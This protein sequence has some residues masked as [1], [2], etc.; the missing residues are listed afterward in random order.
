MEDL[1]KLCEIT[2]QDLR[3]ALDELKG[4]VDVTEEDLMKIYASALVHAKNR[5]KYSISVA[6]LMTKDVVTVKKETTLERP[7]A[8][9]RD[10]AS[11]ACL[12]SMKRRS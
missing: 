8:V 2:E 1:T 6:D 4:Y 5:L 12:L 10:F 7:R 3:A 9:S 11:A